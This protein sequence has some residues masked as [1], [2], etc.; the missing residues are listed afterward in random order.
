MGEEELPILRYGRAIS[1]LCPMHY[2][3]FQ[4]FHQWQENVVEKKKG[5]KEAIGLG[6]WLDVGG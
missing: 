1:M 5:E 6:N 4:R 3:L 2:S